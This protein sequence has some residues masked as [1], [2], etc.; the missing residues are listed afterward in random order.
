MS[1]VM[2]VSCVVG[3][4]ASTLSTDASANYTKRSDK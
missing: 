2:I 4:L 1:K 3:L